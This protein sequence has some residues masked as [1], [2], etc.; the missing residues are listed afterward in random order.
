VDPISLVVGLAIGLL[1]GGGAAWVIA[2]KGATTKREEAEREAKTIAER[3]ELDAERIRRDAELSGR[4][5][6]LKLREEH[7]KKVEREFEKVRDRE[8]AQQKR[9][10]G[11]NER[12]M[13]LDKRQRMLQDVE[14]RVARDQDEIRAQREESAQLLEQRKDE[15]SRTAGLTPEQARD[16]LL[17]SIR[18]DIAE[19][20]ERLIAKSEETIRATCE[21]RGRDIVATAIQ[22]VSAAHTSEITVSTIDIPNDDIKGRIIGREGRNIRAFEKAAGVDVIVDDTPGVV[23]VS[24]FDGVRRPSTRWASAPC[25]ISTSGRCTRSSCT[26]SGDSSTARLT[27]RTCCSTPSSAPTSAG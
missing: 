12:D 13:G 15:L 1:V 9:E 3:A 22:R 11:I 7:E 25:S 5:D 23:L 19:E 4:D 2:G 21:E 20:E 8:R 16:E 6:V 18:I 27:A 14:D 26:S 17:E 10:A 24:A